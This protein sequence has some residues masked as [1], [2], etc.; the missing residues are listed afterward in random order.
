MHA[1]IFCRLVG[2]HRYVMQRQESMQ[3][4][5]GSGKEFKYFVG[6]DCQVKYIFKTGGR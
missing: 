1:D 3:G 4:S 2:L 6:H 5:K